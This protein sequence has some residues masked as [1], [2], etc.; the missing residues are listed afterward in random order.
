MTKA[1]T[2]ESAML[3]LLKALALF[4]E[5]VT[6]EVLVATGDGRYYEARVAGV[7][8]DGRL[9]ETRCSIPTPCW[10]RAVLDRSEA[11]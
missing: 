9:V 2:A 10:A 5:V 6:V 4:H 1:E 3:P 11:P 7:N 8:S